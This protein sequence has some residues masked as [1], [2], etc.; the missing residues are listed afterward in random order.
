MRS[1][2]AAPGETVPSVTTVSCKYTGVTA[3]PKQLILLTS[4]K[5]L[6]PNTV[7]GWGPGGKDFN[8]L[9]LGDTTHP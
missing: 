2:C 1:P 5:T 9:H 6:F 3:T 4:V 8:I 7:S